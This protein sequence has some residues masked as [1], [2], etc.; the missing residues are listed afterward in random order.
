MSSAESRPSQM[1][2]SPTFVG[3]IAALLLGLVILIGLSEVF[4]RL[5]FPTWREFYSGNF[6]QQINVP[7][8]GNVPIGVPNFDGYFS[9]N[10]GNFRV[11]IN[12]NE[13]GLRNQTEV[14]ASHNKLWVVGDS[15][16]FGWGVENHEMYSTLI[17]KY[18]GIPTFNVASPGTNV[19]GYQALVARMPR[20]LR[21]KGVVLGL[22][23]EN[24]ITQYECS[25]TANDVPVDNKK[26]A[27]KGSI[28]SISDVKRRLTQIS[29]IYNFFAVSLKRVDFIQRLLT[30]VGI[31]QDVGNYRDPTRNGSFKAVINKTVS[32]ILNFRRLLP[33]QA[34]LIVLISP[35]RF[36]VRDGDAGY[37]ELRLGVRRALKQA[38]IMFVDPFEQFKAAGYQSV[39][40]THDGHWSPLGHKIAA[41]QV[42]LALSKILR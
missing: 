33:E 34:Q 12:I 28:V 30:S 5:T 36:E 38:G 15:M 8:F 31:I 11:R 29:A 42:S 7:G 17:E 14:D 39:H 20:H 2:Q 27:A 35:G 19:C 41:Q 23:L 16:T 26:T 4:L 6:I 32:E 9:Q 24:D 3:K 40:F 1:N 22:I 25:A 21:P 37:H 10:N 13:F 18:S